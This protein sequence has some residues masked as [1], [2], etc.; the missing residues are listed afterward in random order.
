MVDCRSAAVVPS[1]SCGPPLNAASSS[2]LLIC[3]A[4]LLAM[5]VSASV[6]TFMAWTRLPI[7]PF[8]LVLSHLPLDD[9][10]HVLHWLQCCRA[11]HRILT[12]SDHDVAIWRSVYRT[13]WP[14]IVLPSSPILPSSAA[15]WRGL[16]QHHGQLYVEM[17]EYWNDFSRRV[18]A[19]YEHRLPTACSVHELVQWQQL[20][21]KLLPVDFAFSLLTCGTT[22]PPAA[23][24]LSSSRFRLIARVGPMK[25]CYQ[26]EGDMFLS[27]SDTSRC[28]V[29][30]LFAGPADFSPHS[31]GQL[32]SS[33]RSE[34]FVTVYKYDDGTVRTVIMQVVDQRLQ[35]PTDRTEC[36]SPPNPPSASVIR[37]SKRQ[38]RPVEAQSAHD[39]A[40]GHS[41]R[42]GWLSQPATYQSFQCSCLHTR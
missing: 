38:R 18:P 36:Q 13:A 21:G 15:S 19:G 3:I 39:T 14:F 7:G 42:A 41:T 35:H 32:L 27:L 5:A 24:A 25:A 11:V 9:A 34:Q 22:P 37:A 23:A 6:P 30:E 31:L 29:D 16:L 20:H 40:H 10:F 1:L 12:T 4:P 8:S 2:S 33:A 28:G 17:K 26:Q